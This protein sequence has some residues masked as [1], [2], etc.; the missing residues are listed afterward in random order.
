MRWKCGSQGP[1]RR[2]P[3]TPWVPES[4]PHSLLCSSPTPSLARSL[5]P[6]PRPPGCSPP[7]LGARGGLP[8]P[9]HLRLWVSCPVP[10]FQREKPRLHEVERRPP[11]TL[12]CNPSVAPLGKLRL[13]ERI[14]VPSCGGVEAR[15]ASSP[16]GPHLC[17]HDCTRGPSPQSHLAGGCRAGTPI[18][19]AIFKT[20][21]WGRSAAHRRQRLLHVKSLPFSYLMNT[22]QTRQASPDAAK[23]VLTG[24][25]HLWDAAPLISL[26]FEVPRS[27]LI[28][29][30][31]EIREF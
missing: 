18:S 5:C 29:T 4:S 25:A 28:S 11:G 15:A 8:E 19:P 12:K 21:E 13:G 30:R 10:V 16:C 23:F 26:R 2:E 20:A 9:L 3:A 14:S 24:V 27:P 1:A 22:F 31:F 17:R 6:L 7:L